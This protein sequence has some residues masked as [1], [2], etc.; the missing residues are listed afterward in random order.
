MLSAAQV[1]NDKWTLL[2]EVGWQD[3]STLSETEVTINNLTVKPSLNCQDTYHFALGA[4]YQLTTDT[5]LN[6]GVAYD[7]SMYEEQG[8]TSFLLPAGASWRLGTGVQHQLDERSSIGAAFEWLLS[9]DADV[10]SPAELA[11]SSYN[12]V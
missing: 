5:R 1:L 12:F 4:Q 2:G 6:F 3:W 11:G 8:D 7:T 9:E 10:R